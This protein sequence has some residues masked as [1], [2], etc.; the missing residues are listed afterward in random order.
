MMFKPYKLFP[1]MCLVRRLK[2]LKNTL[3]KIHFMSKIGNE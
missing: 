1:W 3:E 2:D